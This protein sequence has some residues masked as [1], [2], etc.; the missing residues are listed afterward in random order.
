MRAEGQQPASGQVPFHD[1]THSGES[2]TGSGVAGPATSAG[3]ATVSNE[4][5]SSWST[6]SDNGTSRVGVDQAWATV[7]GH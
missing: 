6:L 7:S 4:V 2:H 5:T 3:S 1:G